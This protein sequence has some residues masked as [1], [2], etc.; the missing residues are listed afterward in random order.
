[1]NT[2]FEQQHNAQQALRLLRRFEALKIAALPIQEKYKQI[3]GMYGKD[4]DTVAK[5]YQDNRLDPVIGRNMPPVAGKIAWARQ[6]YR[7]IS[8]PMEVFQK[9]PPALLEDMEA[10]RII[11]T[12]NRL[13]RVLIEY[14][15]LYHRGWLRQV[16][17]TFIACSFH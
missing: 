13:S 12:Y 5:I 15:V 16:R 4:I 14:E 8:D 11:R 6:L 10:K 2:K 17:I 1:M 7:Q 9:Q 3:L